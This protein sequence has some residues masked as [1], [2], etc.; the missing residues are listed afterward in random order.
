[1][2][3]IKLLFWNLSI[4]SCLNLNAQMNLSWA[5]NIGGSGADEAQA[6]GTDLSGNVF[7]AGSFNGTVDFDPGPGTFTITS[8]GGADGYV[9]KYDANGNFINAVSF[10]NNLDCKVYALALDNLGNVIVTGGFTGSVD[11]DPSA[12]VTLLVAGGYYDIF[13]V[14]LNSNLGFGWAHRFGYA[15]ADDYGFSVATDN[16]NNI[17][18]TGNFQGSNIDFD[19]GGS[20]YY[21]SSLGLKDVF[22]LKLDANAS[23]V[24]AFGIGGAASVQDIGQTIKTDATGNIIVGGYFSYLADFDPSVSTQTLVS[25]GNYDAFIA[26]YSP[27]GTYIWAKKFSGIGNEACYALQPDASGDIY[28]TGTFAGGTSCDFDPGAAT[29][30]LTSNGLNED[31]FVTKLTSAGNFVW[32][33]SMGGVSADY[34]RAIT[35]DANTIYISGYYSGVAD[36]DP[37]PSTNTLISNGGT[38]FFISRLDLSGNF[39]SAYNY[40]ALGNDYN[41]SICSSASGIIYAAGSFSN[42]VDFDHSSG[43]QT[44]TSSG[45]NDAYFFKLQNNTVSIEEL[46][47]VNSVQIFP[48][49]FSETVKL[50][51]AKNCEV[52]VFN[53]LGQSVFET[54]IRDEESVLDLSSLC[55]GI[56]YLKIKKPSKLIQTIKIIKQ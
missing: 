11:F 18:V 20:T 26:K 19:P 32:A 3:K 25:G 10:T 44:L 14:K 47:T 12:G 45:L 38:D 49:P 43:T 21:L 7:V 33:K 39:L 37:S 8:A 16:S 24:W 53:I 36:F 34:G 41:Y 51:N 55:Q 48:N 6:I 4:L 2:K 22:V 50:T 52:S 23:F 9:A 13:V 29:F 56:Y 5:K 31:V 17:L 42:T 27:S 46:S 40:G 30:N 54:E 15:S 35:L 1:M 28:C